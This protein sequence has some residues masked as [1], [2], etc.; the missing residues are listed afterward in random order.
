MARVVF[1]AVQEWAGVREGWEFKLGSEGLGYYRTTSVAATPRAECTSAGGGG[2]CNYTAYED[3]VLEKCE[4][5]VEH[6]RTGAR[7][8]MRVCG[9]NPAGNVCRG[10]SAYVPGSSVSCVTAGQGLPGGAQ[11]QGR[12]REVER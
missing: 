5:T 10:C 1:E 11:C 8:D 3:E 2:R 7:G 9:D 6:P 4:A 12:G